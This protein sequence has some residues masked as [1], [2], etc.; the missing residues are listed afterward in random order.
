LKVD[1]YKKPVGLMGD[2]VLLL[3]NAELALSAEMRVCAECPGVV[4][5]TSKPEEPLVSAAW[6]VLEAAN[7]LD[8]ISTITACQ[9]IIDASLSGTLPRQADINIVFGFF[10]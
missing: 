5:G 3:K 4:V 6:T 2:F 10:T 8:D 7:D 9:R 1:A